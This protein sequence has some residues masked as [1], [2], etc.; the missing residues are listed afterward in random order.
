M[1][2]DMSDPCANQAEIADFPGSEQ[3]FIYLLMSGF[4]N[5]KLN[6]VEILETIGQ[7]RLLSLEE[8]VSCLFDGY[9]LQAQRQALETCHPVFRREAERFLTSASSVGH[10]G[11]DQATY[12]CSVFGVS[13][14]NV[15][16]KDE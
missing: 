8:L 9:E 4:R 16:F 6:P 2:R 15:E 10:V 3:H 1:A 13:S 7:H 12:F 11:H 14:E 5:R